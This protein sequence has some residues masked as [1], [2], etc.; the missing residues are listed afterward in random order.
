M[1]FRSERD[2]L[3]FIYSNIVIGRPDIAHYTLDCQPWACA[4]D[5]TCYMFK[6]EW[7][8][9]FPDQFT[10][11]YGIADGLL[12]NALVARGIRHGKLPQVLVVHN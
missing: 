11:Q 12:V 9:P 4:I 1:L 2:N 6:R 8:Q 10:G 3:E 5:K 7:F